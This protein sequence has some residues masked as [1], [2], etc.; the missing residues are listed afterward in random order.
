MKNVKL[1]EG[2]VLEIIRMS[3]EDGPGIRTTVFLKGCTL[4]CSWCH[5]P[6]SISAKP[7][8]QWIGSNC[9]GCNICVDTCKQHAL[10]RG[11]EGIVIDRHGIVRN[12][13]RS[14][15]RTGLFLRSQVAGLLCQV[16]RLPCSWILPLRCLRGLEKGELKLHWIPVDLFPL[17]HLKYLC[18]TAAL[19]YM[20]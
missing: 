13:L 10:T 5:N 3:T 6:E 16:E 11:A 1:P 2:N 4:K 7:Q 9:I 12:L 18:H 8:V 15:L 17:N 20:I 14:L 19:S